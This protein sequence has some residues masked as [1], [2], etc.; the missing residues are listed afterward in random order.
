MVHLGTDSFKNKIILNSLVVVGFSFV[1]CLIGGVWYPKQVT[2]RRINI[3]FSQG[4]FPKA[5]LLI[6]WNFGE[7]AV[8]YQSE[9][10]LIGYANK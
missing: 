3:I 1:F 2:C 9:E 8:G 5:L 4:L 10:Y 6:L 7:Q